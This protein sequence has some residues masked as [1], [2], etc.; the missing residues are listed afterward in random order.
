MTP[1]SDGSPVS[2]DVDEHEQ[3]ERL[4]VVLAARLDESRSRA[5]GRIERGEVTVGGETA[6][7][8]HRVAPGERVVV[9]PRVEERLP[10]P[11]LPPVR[12]RDE[13]LLVVAKP[14][15]LVV[16]PGPG[17]PG[18]TL[19]DALR[20]ADVPLAAG[21]GPERPGIVHRL[22]RDTSGLLVVASTDR[23]HQGLVAALKRRDVG[24]RYVTLVEGSLGAGRGRVEAPIGRHA[25][26]RQRF[27]VVVGGRPAVTH[28]RV[29]AE[30]EVDGAAVSLL[31]CRLE[32]GRTHQIRVHLS[33]AGHPVVADRTYGASRPLATALD[34]DRP[35]L[36][37]WRL[38]FAHPV[39]GEE[40]DVV[41]PVPADLQAAAGR[42][43]V[44]E[45]LPA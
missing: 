15:G 20:A 45:A 34:L 35:F 13:H 18:G 38:T 14:A 3:G 2:F 8:S 4:D 17:W 5:A 43:G 27:G 42:A 28:W 31:R 44:A 23:A 21:S 30:S 39:T 26:D 9:A 33:E 19:V 24:R 32:T 36:H 41:E 1:G 6:A 29:D 25:T 11:P 10:P 7:K 22:D 40:V 37:A 16:H 12:Y